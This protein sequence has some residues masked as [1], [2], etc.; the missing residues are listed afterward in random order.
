MM[1]AA[2]RWG[3]INWMKKIEA[4]QPYAWPHDGLLAAQRTAILIIDM[5]RD[6]CEPG[7]YLASAGAD[8]AGLAA[9]I[10]R[11]SIVRASLSAWG[12]T[13]IH[14]R[15]GHKPDLADLFSA[16]RFRSHNACAEI[17]SSGPLG[18]FLIRGERGW[19]FIDTLTPA[20]NELVIDKPGYSA[21]RH[22]DLDIVLRARS[23]SKLIVC[24]TTTDVCVSSTVR[25]ATELG[26][27][28]L[29]LRDCCWSS[30]SACHEATFVTITSEGGI[31][32]AVALSVDV[33]GMIAAS[34]PQ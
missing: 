32:G 3:L 28:C 34:F 13:V 14:T 4:A 9:A 12:A 2:R 1:S 5:Q 16:K 11:I 31:F 20:A 24:G 27:E 23:I 10:N 26:Y 22:T 17:G 8:L 18:R 6:F 19:D 30:S 25:D 7:G 21:F 33:L 15:E 29:T